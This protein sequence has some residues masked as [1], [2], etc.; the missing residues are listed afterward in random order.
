MSAF[1]PLPQAE[2]DSVIHLDKGLFA[3]YVLMIVCPTPNKGVEL[4]YQVSC[5]SLL[6]GL[7]ITLGIRLKQIADFLNEESY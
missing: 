4:T 6:I 7:N 5:C 3:G 1:S 2:I